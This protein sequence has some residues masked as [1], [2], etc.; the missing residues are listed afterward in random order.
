[1][2]WLIFGAFYL[3]LVSFFLG[4]FVLS[5]RADDQARRTEQQLLETE[6]SETA[7]HAVKIHRL[8]EADR[9]HTDTTTSP[10]EN[11][12]ASDKRLTG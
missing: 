12:T 9:E 2:V 7:R 11:D 3:L 1:M 4:A 5:R 8:V 6:Q 10:L